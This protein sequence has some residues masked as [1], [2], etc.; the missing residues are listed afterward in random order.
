[1]MR[2][3]C[4]ATLLTVLLLGPPS[5]L[6]A[7]L[8]VKPLKLF[9]TPDA[10]TANL[11]ISNEGD[12]PISVQLSARSWKQGDIGEDL[13]DE[14]PDIVFFPKIVQI[15]PAEDRVIRIGYAGEPAGPVE[16]SYRI[17]AQELPVQ[18][19]GEYAMKFTVR[20]GIPIFVRSSYQ[21]TRWALGA[22]EMTGFGLKIPVVN[23]SG[24]HVRVE[25]LQVSGLD[26]QG[27]E[28]LSSANNGWYVLAERT[29]AFVLPIDPDLCANA[30][31]LKFSATVNDATRDRQMDLDPVACDRLEEPRQ[32]TSVR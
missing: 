30:K 6:G 16:K 4:T 11:T 2:L 5:A 14:T 15:A 23:Q 25:N 27:E 19:P 3:I 8:K 18:D 17:Y 7:G 12:E 13:Y 24:Q 9:F 28:V 29:R 21:E 10:N 31:T 32:T 20:M 1:M 26:A 22:G